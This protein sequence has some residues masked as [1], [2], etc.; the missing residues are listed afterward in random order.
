MTVIFFLGLAT[1][2]VP[3]SLG[4]AWLSIV[5]KVY[6]EQVFLIG[7]ALLIFYGILSFFG[8]TV[9]F[10]MKWQPDLSKPTNSLGVYTLGI[11]SGIASSCCAPV[12]AGM[13]TLTA[14]TASLPLAFIISL[15]Y[16]L[17]MTMPLF[18]LAL[19]W[20]QQRIGQSKIFKGLPITFRFGSWKHIVHSTH[21]LVSIIFVTIGSYVIY[22][23]RHGESAVAA[24]WQITLSASFQSFIQSIA[25]S[26]SQHP[27]ISLVVYS[28]VILG[29]LGLMRAIKYKEV[30]Q[31]AQ[32]RSSHE[33]DEQHCH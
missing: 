11:F 29:W 21:L 2:L 7:G 16:I 33:K 30:R 3:I 12:L 24:P 4:V 10:P 26:A 8:K 14:L 18:I 15:T 17:G 13:L 25:T 28:L 32:E 23:A 1:I 20:D 6:H 5:F 31:L 19:I 27:L 9:M 22:V